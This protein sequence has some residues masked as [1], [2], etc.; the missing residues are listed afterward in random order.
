MIAR[1]GAAFGW[2]GSH[3]DGITAGIALLLIAVGSYQYF[4]TRS[5]LRIEKALDVLKRREGKT[6]VSAKTALANMWMSDEDLCENFIKSDK[7]TASMTDR[8]ADL[9]IADEDYRDAVAD[10]STYYTNVAACTLDGICDAS[11]MCA[12][13]MGEIQDFVEVNVDYFA[14]VTMVRREDAKSLTLSMPEFLGFCE[15]RLRLHVASR[16]D[17]SL[18]CQLGRN[19]YRH[20]GTGFG[21]FCGFEAS[22]YDQQVKT[23]ADS[24][25]D[26]VGCDVFFRPHK[27]TRSHWAVA[28]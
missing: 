2:L 28:L 21:W 10:L 4:K 18:L 9:I 13:L 27:T 11:V 15:R 14:R 16:H 24:L 8:V 26:T 17:H 7:Y 25:R 22:E 12:S 6:F 5:D 1:I 3:R 19:L 23:K 20:L